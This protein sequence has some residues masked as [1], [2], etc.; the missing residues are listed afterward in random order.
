MLRVYPFVSYFRM[1]PAD[2]PLSGPNA[3]SCTP[4]TCVHLLR[5]DVANTLPPCFPALAPTVSYVIPLNRCV[6]VD[7][8]QTFI[9]TAAHAVVPSLLL[10]LA[11]ALLLL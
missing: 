1:V 4:S 9:V 8:F 11:L 10:L 3:G 7:A 6:A 2:G 5:H